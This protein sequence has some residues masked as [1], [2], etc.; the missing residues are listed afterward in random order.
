MR[1][2]NILITAAFCLVHALPALPALAEDVIFPPNSVVGLKPPGA[3]KA[4]VALP[5][6]EDVAQD[7]I[8]SIFAEPRNG[9]H[10]RS[11][12]EFGKIEKVP[13]DKT[14]DS[15][16]QYWKLA[17]GVEAHVLTYIQKRDGIVQRYWTVAARDADLLAII[18]ARAAADSA[19]YSNAAMQ[20][21]LRTLRFRKT[22]PQH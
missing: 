7:A 5:I 2:L 21:A 6:F 11:F 13:S 14:I 22:P 17:D 4:H 19:L 12:S 18:F 20:A 3:M 15:P 9:S 10:D 16:I 1:P 8:I